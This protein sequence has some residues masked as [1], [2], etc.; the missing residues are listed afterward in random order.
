MFPSLVRAITPTMHCYST[1][2]S[3]LE[4]AEPNL[5]LD[6]IT[7]K[8][9]GE[10][11][12]GYTKGALPLLLDRT[13]AMMQRSQFPAATPSSS[14]KSN[15][16]STNAMCRQCHD[17]DLPID[18]PDPSAYCQTNKMLVNSEDDLRVNRQSHSLVS[19]P[20]TPRTPMHSTAAHPSP[21]PHSACLPPA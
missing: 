13:Y 21:A 6:F 3:H 18:L 10:V 9:W 12:D 20:S 19:A 15:T 17:P 16:P 5:P 14:C 2:R 8:Y 7:G 1:R 11:I 4:L